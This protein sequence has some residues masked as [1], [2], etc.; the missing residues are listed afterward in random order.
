MYQWKRYSYI[1][2]K[3]VDCNIKNTKYKLYKVLPRLSNLI[4]HIILSTKDYNIIN[5]INNSAWFQQTNE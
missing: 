5:T 4:K 3:V 1:K 2:F